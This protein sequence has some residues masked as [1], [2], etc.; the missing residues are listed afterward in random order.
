[1]NDLETSGV[2]VQ[3]DYASVRLHVMADHVQLQQVVLNLVKNAIDAMD[4]QAASTRKL[5]VTTR[6]RANSIFLL[7]DDSGPGIPDKT[8]DRVFDPFF[9]TKLNGMGRGPHSA[10]K[11][12][13]R[14]AAAWSSRGAVI[15]ARHFKSSCRSPRRCRSNGV[16][17]IA[18]VGTTPTK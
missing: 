13:K 11:L 4:A 7:I 16:A 1:L 6:H 9:T 2:F 12:S 10:G 8:R 5:Q 3:K 14:T 15:L 18:E 17:S